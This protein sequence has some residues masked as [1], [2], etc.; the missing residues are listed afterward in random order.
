MAL[1]ILRLVWNLLVD[2]VLLVNILQ[3]VGTDHC[4]QIRLHKVKHQV[5]VL[6]VFGTDYGEEC[7]DVGMASQF[8]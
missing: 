7:D 4:V 5:E 2:D 1:R 8:L 6:I 3:Q